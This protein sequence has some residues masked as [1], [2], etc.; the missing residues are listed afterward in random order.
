V[1][2]RRDLAAAYAQT[3]Y[4][5]TID[6]AIFEL[7]IGAEAPAFAAWLAARGARDWGWLTSVNP[8]SRRLAESE[9]RRRLAAL[10]RRLEAA[11]GRHWPGVAVDPAGRWPDEPSFLVLDLTAERLAALAAR[12]GQHA[13][14]AGAAD[15]RAE[16]CWVGEAPAG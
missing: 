2:S 9:N 5:V 4:R 8:R 14:L 10:R 6:G 15:G 13:F 11:G 1:T 12:F 7:R 16:L 3:L